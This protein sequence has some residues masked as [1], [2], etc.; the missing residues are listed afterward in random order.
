M[1][2]PYITAVMSGRKRGATAAFLGGVLRLLSLVYA[3]GVRLVWFGYSSGLRRVYAAPIAVVSVGNLTLGGTGKTPMVVYLA[4]YFVSRGSKPAVLTRGYGND[5]CRMLAAELPEVPVYNGQDRLKNARFAA[6]DGRDVVILDD[7]FQHRRIG[8]DF[9]ILLVDGRN[10]FGNGIIFPGGILRE[11]V[12]AARRAD[13]IIIT[14]IDGLSDKELQ[15]I[16]EY[17]GRIAPGKA[18]AASRHDPVS[19]GGVKGASYELETIRGKDICVVSGIADPS[20]L[21]ALLKSLGSGIKK[22][23]FYPDH[24]AYKQKDLDGIVRE[25]VSLGIRTIVTTGKDF[26]KM[27]DLDMSAMGDNIRILNVETKITEGRERLIAGL[28]SVFSHIGG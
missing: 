13:L 26:V 11:P 8:R 17:I 21:E 5:E 7:A 27:Q 28:D 19:F 25:C 4:N 15:E 3:A 23:Y 16:K 9:N 2:V 6:R 22:T 12:E 1:F 24:Y 10:L 18:V 14:K 20:Y